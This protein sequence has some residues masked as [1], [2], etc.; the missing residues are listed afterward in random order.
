METMYD[1][2][3][4]KEKKE[5]ELHQWLCTPDRIIPFTFIPEPET[6]VLEMSDHSILGR[7]NKVSKDFEQIFSEFLDS[8][9]DYWDKTPTRDSSTGEL[10][11]E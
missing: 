10:T 5:H 3:S 7:I 11:Y 8:V 2:M 4:E 6:T 1:M 9:L